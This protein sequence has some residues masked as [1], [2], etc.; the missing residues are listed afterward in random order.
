MGRD[1]TDPLKLA[2]P[3]P[4]AAQVVDQGGGWLLSQQIGTTPGVEADP[5]VD[6]GL[7]H[8]GLD[9]LGGDARRFSLYLHLIG[10]K[11]GRH[12]RQ[13]LQGAAEGDT[14]ETRWSGGVTSGKT[15]HQ[16]S[17]CLLYPGPYRSTKPVTA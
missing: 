10:G 7:G 2:L 5:V 9:Y 6:T 13:R 16:S 17:F 14:G 15:G 1:G 3:L 8:D 11:G 12:D 4:G